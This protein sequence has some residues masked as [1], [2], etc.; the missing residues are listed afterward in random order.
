MKQTMYLLAGLFLSIMMLACEKTENEKPN[1]ILIMVDDIGIGD[2][3]CLGNKIIKTP[4]ID[5][6][7]QESIRL[8]DYHVSPTCAPTRAAIMTGHHNYRTGVFFT[9]KG[10][11]LIMKKETTMAQIFKDNGYNTAMFGK[12]HLGDN[13]PFRPQDKGFEEVL[14]LNGGGIGQ[15][16]DYWDNDYFDDKYR[17][18]GVLEQFQGYCTDVWF[19][20]AKKYIGQ[21]RD[22]PFFC[23]L[24]TNAA[25]SPYWV[26][27]KYSDPYK[28]NEEVYNPA[29]YGMIANI[30]ENIGQLVAYLKSIDLMD[31]TI[32]IF[33]ADNGSA[34][35]AQV[36]P[37]GNRLDGFVVKGN[38]DGMRGI[39][40]SMYEGG[41]RV[42]FFMHWKDG[43]I[44]VGKDIDALTAHYDVL[45]TLIDLC[46]LEVS[47]ELK[48]DG[49]SMV[50]LLEGKDEA[51]EDRTI[52]VNT[53]F[54][55]DPIPW[56]RTA[57]LHKR[58]RLIE[59]T[60]LYNL[61]TDPEQRTNV[62]DRYP[63]KVAAFKAEYDKWW[64]EISPT[65][66]EKPF[67]IIGNDAENPMTLHGHD[68]H[69][70]DFTP[71]SQKHIRSGYLNNGFW[72]VNVAQAGTYRMQLRRWPVESG[73]ALNDPAPKRP[74]L[75]STSVAASKKGKALNIQN[76]KVKIQDVELSAPVE[77]DEKYIEFTMELAKGESHLQTWFTME[78][79]VEI[80]AYFVNV[81]KIN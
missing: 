48:F 16:L 37:K 27:D 75:K 53:Q 80:G 43:G 24:S 7:H 64:S 52:F 28:A 10:R 69:S 3:A 50:P 60:E 32:L 19:E 6:L 55:T 31:N 67:F 17:R 65:F 8:T 66:A 21:D 13:Y 76:A 77:G 47:P 39:K 2:L 49:Q 54:S 74:A 5:A 23:Y 46:Q 35:G 38:N 68:W 51:F 30:D 72:R 79:G 29:F 42:P 58:W 33:T 22:K 44:T 41:H 70:D 78:D 34:A 11:S 73:L 25:H 14:S 71:W 36:D 45:P 59:G 9:I 57:L 56:L 4:H 62:A 18:N 81:E 61:D 63:E 40:A 1:V 26:A 15:A 12:W 20:N